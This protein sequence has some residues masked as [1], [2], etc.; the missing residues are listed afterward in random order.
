MVFGEIAS[1]ET[2]RLSIMRSEPTELTPHFPSGNA[3]VISQVDLG[4]RGFIK[5]YTPF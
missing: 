4:K 1:P 5:E 3:K 2:E